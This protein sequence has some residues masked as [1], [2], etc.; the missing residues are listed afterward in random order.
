MKDPFTGLF[1]DD[2]RSR[3]GVNASERTEFG[4]IRAL[5]TI[6]HCV[7]SGARVN[8]EAREELHAWNLSL[9]RLLARFDSVCA[10]RV[11]STRFAFDSSSSTRGNSNGSKSSLVGWRLSFSE[12]ASASTWRSVDVACGSWRCARCGGAS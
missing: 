8:L 4:V 2:S 7:N 10:S 11:A 12:S 3:A 9:R 1:A 5:G 6:S